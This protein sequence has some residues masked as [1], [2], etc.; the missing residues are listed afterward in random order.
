M[1][2]SGVYMT[3]H[4]VY[5]TKHGVYMTKHGVYMTK[6]GGVVLSQKPALRRLEAENM[7]SKAFLGY[8]KILCLKK[9]AK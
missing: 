7:E 9:K 5:M 8:I 4:G 3:K 6:H 2:T 1:L